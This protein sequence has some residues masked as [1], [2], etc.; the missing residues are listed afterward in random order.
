MQFERKLIEI[1][2]SLMLT[3][4]S[5]LCKYLDMKANDVITIQDESKKKGKF[6]SLWKKEVE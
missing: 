1:G 5:E 4:P 2:G 3:I 6:V